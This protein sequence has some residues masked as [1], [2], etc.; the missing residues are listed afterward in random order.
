[1]KELETKTNLVV[2]GGGFVNLKVA[3]TR[4]QKVVARRRAAEVIGRSWRDWPGL[5]WLLLRLPLLLLLSQS[6]A[7]K[8]ANLCSLLGLFAH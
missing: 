3:T 8:R 6:V 4:L 5:A 2:G 7:N 1:M